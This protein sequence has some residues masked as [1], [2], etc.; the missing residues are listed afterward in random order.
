MANHPSALKR[1]RQSL[2]R[3]ARNRARKSE[4][5]TLVKN[6]RASE[7]KDTVLAAF[8]AA[9]RAID[10]AKSKGTLHAKTASRKISRLARWVNSHAKAA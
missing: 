7:G 9:V 1:Y 3:Q 6:T 5:K 2:R 8:E 10:K 4:L